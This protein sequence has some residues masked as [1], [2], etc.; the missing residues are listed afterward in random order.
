VRPE[1]GIEFTLSRGS[2]YDSARHVIVFNVNDIAAPGARATVLHEYGHAALG[3][4]RRKSDDE[5]F[6][7]EMAAWKWATAQVRAKG[8]KWTEAER[9]EIRE[10][11]QSYIEGRRRGWK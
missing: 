11:V 10:S 9:K 5:I 3:H 2:Y 8:G 7:G 6:P 1:P 4:G